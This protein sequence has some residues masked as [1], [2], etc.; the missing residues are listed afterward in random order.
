MK[1]LKFSEIL[2]LNLEIKD[3][4]KSDSYKVSV[5]TNITIHQITEVLEYSLR[6]E[7]INADVQIGDYDNIIQNTIHHKHSDAVIIFW[8]LSNIIEGLHFKIEL[9]N[10]KQFNEILEKIKS[11]I[12]LVLKNLKNTSL[13]LINKFTP[14]HWCI[15]NIKKCNLEKLSEQLNQ[16]LENNITANTSLIDL[17]KVIAS[18]GIEKSHDLRY[19]YSSKSLYTIN[20]LKFYVDC[21]KPLIMTVNGK[22][23]KVLIFDCDNT[24]WKGILGED[25]FDGIEMSP[26]TK[27]GEIFF[28]IQSIVLAL[29]MQ[30]ILIGICSKNNPADVEKVINSHP[31]MLLRSKYI[32]IN[33][34]NWLDKVTNLKEIVREL[35]VG[36]DSLVFIDDSP[37]EV[38]LIKE[39]LPE[40]TVL[41]VPERLYEYPKLLRD[42]I[43]LFHGHSLTFEDKNKVRMYKQQKKRNSIKSEFF[44]IEDYIASLGLKMTIYV[45]DKSL[46]P[47]ISQMTQKTNQFNLT[48]KR[49]T[50]GDIERFIRDR[51]SNVVAFSVSDKFGDSGITGL[52]II[53]LYDGG[54]LAELDTF[55]MSCRIIGRNLEHAFIYCIIDFLKDNEVK[56]VQS[57]Y[58]KTKKN[59]QVEEFYEGCSFNVVEQTD[60]VKNYCLNIDN[61]NQKQIDYI[62]IIYD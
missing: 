5:L 25:G 9:F 57:Q 45:D 14:M 59:E 58:I 18:V 43:G 47:R 28:E 41:Q 48:T 30:G 4:L 38:N 34:S 35:N 27:D 39:Q 62:D 15:S 3:T 31:D 40:I 36:L 2:E 44:G 17:N 22:V 11:E 21:I 56:V 10:D 53:T 23:K 51:C 50:E 24:L 32:T 7:G 33:K 16:Y 37:F 55:L 13:V 8:E 52:S 46:I 60:F 1:N 61:Y 19:Y 6:V 20:F 12:L 54:R 29:N 42:N 49:Y 26:K